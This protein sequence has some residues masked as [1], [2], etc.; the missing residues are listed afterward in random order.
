MTTILE[1]ESIQREAKYGTRGIKANDKWYNFDEKGN[2]DG[3]GRGTKL[4]IVSHT[5]DKRGKLLVTKWK[6]VGGGTSGASGS[7]GG[8]GGG[9]GG[10]KPGGYDAVDWN[11]ATARAIETVGVLLAHDALALGAKG[12]A[13]DRRAIIIATIDELTA[14]FFTEGK[15][16]KSL[17]KAKEIERDLGTEEDEGLED[18]PAGSDEDEDPFA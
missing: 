12:K 8:N 16:R 10:G 1:V 17:K 14:H 5:K 13:D 6:I 2:F 18:E 4:E 7:A 3:I 11:A 15:E 9:N